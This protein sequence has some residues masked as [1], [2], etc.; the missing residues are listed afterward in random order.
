MFLDGIYVTSVSIIT[1]HVSFMT[2]DDY[3]HFMITIQTYNDIKEK[4]FLE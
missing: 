1:E 2:V 3:G 4:F